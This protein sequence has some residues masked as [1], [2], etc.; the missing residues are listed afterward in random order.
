MIELCNGLALELSSE[1][2]LSNHCRNQD[3]HVFRTDQGSDAV[4]LLPFL[5]GCEA[6]WKLSLWTQPRT[7]L[8]PDML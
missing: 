1:H 8:T 2:V 6:N 7:L 5:S 3:L 4:I